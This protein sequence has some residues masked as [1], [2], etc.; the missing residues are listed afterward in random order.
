M[1]RN[2]LLQQLYLWDGTYTSNNLCR[3]PSSLMAFHI[4]C[5][6]DY[7]NVYEISSL[8]TSVQCTQFFTRCL[9]SGWGPYY[10]VYCTSRWPPMAYVYY[11]YSWALYCYVS[12][13]TMYT[14][15]LHLYLKIY[16]CTILMSDLFF[17]VVLH[18]S[19]P[20][21]VIRYCGH[22]VA[23]WPHTSCTPLTS[24]IRGIFHSVNFHTQYIKLWWPFPISIQTPF[25]PFSYHFL[26]A[27]MEPLKSHFI[28]YTKVT[29][30]QPP[31]M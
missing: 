17:H 22:C 5:L 20:D 16:H 7:V 4:C 18:Y 28:I 6:L 15:Y 24:H 26:D 31:Y 13:T 8:M 2:I 21:I 10:T 25:I 3:R 9:H 11:S 27:P 12:K 14:S 1:A 29:S 19:T 23:L 30:L